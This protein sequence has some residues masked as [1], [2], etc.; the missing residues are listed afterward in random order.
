MTSALGQPRPRNATT[1][2]PSCAKKR[3]SRS[4][5]SSGKGL[6]HDDPLE[7]ERPA[8]AGNCRQHGRSRHR[9]DGFDQIKNLAIRARALVGKKQLPRYHEKIQRLTA[10]VTDEV[11]K[12]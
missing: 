5:W 9:G 6:C 10:Q 11:R 12:G 2:M 4:S 3:A 1:S 8:S 7:P